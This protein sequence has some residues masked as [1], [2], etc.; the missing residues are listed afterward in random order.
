MAVVKTGIGM[1]IVVAVG[2]LTLEIP[3]I[4]FLL[5]SG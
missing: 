5:P 2:C 1:Q 4:P 3:I